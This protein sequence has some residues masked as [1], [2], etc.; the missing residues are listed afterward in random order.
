MREEN[1]VSESRGNSSE[2]FCYKEKQITVVVVGGEMES[3]EGG[4]CGFFLR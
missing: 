4:L 3:G 2:E 1:L